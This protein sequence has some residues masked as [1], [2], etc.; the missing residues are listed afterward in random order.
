MCV[1]FVFE[2][3]DGD[4]SVDTELEKAGDFEVGVG[5]IEEESCRGTTLRLSF[6]EDVGTNL[7]GC[8]WGSV[9]GIS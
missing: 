9:V 3:G 2:R 1:E 6:G 4:L 5:D 7:G 8:C